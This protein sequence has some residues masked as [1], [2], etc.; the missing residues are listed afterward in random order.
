MWIHV[1]IYIH[2]SNLDNPG[3]TERTSTN[4]GRSHRLPHVCTIMI[5]MVNLGGI[6]C[7][8]LLHVYMYIYIIH[9]NQRPIWVSLMWILETYNDITLKR[10]IANLGRSH[11]L[12]CVFLTIS[13]NFHKPMSV[14]YIFSSI[15][16]VFA[17]A[18][19]YLC[20]YIYISMPP[21]MSGDRGTNDNWSMLDGQILYMQ[22]VGLMDYQFQM[23]QLWMLGIPCVLGVLPYWYGYLV[24]S[25]VTYLFGTPPTYGHL[26]GTNGPMMMNTWSSAFAKRNQTN[27]NRGPQNYMLNQNYIHLAK[28]KLL[29]FVWSPPWHLYILFLANLLAFYL[30]YLLAFY[31]AYLL[32]FYL[33]YLLAY[34]LLKSSGILS[35]KHS[36]TLSGISSGILS[37]FLSGISSGILSGISS[38][39]LSGISSG[40]LSGISSNILSGISSGK[41]HGISSGI[42][43]WPLRSSGARW[44]GKVPGWGPAVHAGKV[45][46]RLRSSGARWEGPRLRSSSAHWAGKVPGWGPAVR[47]ELGRSQDEVQQ[48]ALS[49]E[50][51]EELG[52]EL[53]RRKWRWKL[54][55]TW[56]R[57]NWTR[58]RRRRRRRR[59]KRRRRRRRRRATALIKSKNPHLAGGEKTHEDLTDLRGRHT[60]F[61]NRPVF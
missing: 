59:T 5:Y 37:D 50:V 25:K 29:Y 44:A 11:R 52:E 22:N 46:P 36:G 41:S 19:I 12:P 2:I 57:R 3:L 35:G 55:Q 34:Y 14:Q 9:R 4:L 18:Y 7:R 23:G 32:A 13:I 30:T 58:R 38:N 47:S 10:G 26:K 17:V 49:S 15:A 43:I 31:L 8:K 39:I 45:P 28:Q 1:Y 6:A 48:C 21:W 60:P 54:M 27:P 33:A 42:S 51:G 53:A 16:G 20:I 24:G 61:S 40:T 56:S